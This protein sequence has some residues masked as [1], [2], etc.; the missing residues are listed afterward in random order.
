MLKI[1]VSS[2]LLGHP[3]RYDAQ[4]KPVEHPL[5]QQWQAEGRLVGFCPEQASGL[6]TPRPPA[7]R[8]GELICTED[9]S[10]MTTA[11]TKGAHQAL[12]QCQRQDIRVALLKESSPSC[13]STTIYDGQFRG[14]KIPGMGLTAEQLQATG[15]MV[16]SENQLEE[17][18]NFLRQIEK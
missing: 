15:I 4:S 2:C 8:R 17:L 18:A 1:L 10:D 6:P 11:F 14:H 12:V 3:V 7:E 13:G 5:L 16:F 9:G